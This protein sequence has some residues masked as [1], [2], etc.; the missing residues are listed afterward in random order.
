MV[1]Q[2]KDDRTFLL[3]DGQQR[4]T[5]LSLMALAVVQH[6]HQMAEHGNETAENLE[7][8]DLLQAQFLGEKDPASLI[9]TWKLRLNRHCN[10]F[11][12]S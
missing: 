2:P 4:L 12:L 11:Y 1:L 8:A 7:R 5:T 6:L 10:E 3:V 9:H